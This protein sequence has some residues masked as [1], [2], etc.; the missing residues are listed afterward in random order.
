M[1]NINRFYEKYWGNQALP[2]NDPTTPK[3]ITLLLE[4]F[5]KLNISKAKILDAGCG[6]GFFCKLFRDIGFDV[7]GVDISENA[8]NKAKT[9]YPEIEFKV[10]VLDDKILYPDK[11]Y[12][13]VWSSEVIEHV[14]YVYNYLSEINRVLKLGGYYILTTPYHGLIKNLLIV[15]LRFD[16]HFCNLEGGHLRFFTNKALHSLLYKFGF[17]VIEFR[18]NGRIPFLARS[19]YI[20]AKK[21][22]DTEWILL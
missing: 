3:R 12:E 10:S 5:R 18:Y 7:C 6:S 21:F 2:E 19:I 22:K 11:F 9:L 17:D 1:T 20:V 14:F 4:T 16:E 8:I 15:L 13:I